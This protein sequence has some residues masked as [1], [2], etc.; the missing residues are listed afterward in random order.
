MKLKIFKFENDIMLL[1]IGDISLLRHKVRAK[2]QCIRFPLL[3]FKAICDNKL[4]LKQ[5]QCPSSL[6]LIQNMSCHEILQ[7]FMV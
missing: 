4:E 5:R 3:A 7:V 2:R 6:T 1:L